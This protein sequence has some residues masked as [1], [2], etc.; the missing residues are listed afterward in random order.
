MYKIMQIFQL[1]KYVFSKRIIIAPDSNIRVALEIM[2]LINLIILII[3]YP[4]ELCFF[5]EKSYK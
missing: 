3:A 4:I 1:L 2:F 5:D